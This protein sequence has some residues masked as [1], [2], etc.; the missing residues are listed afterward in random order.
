MSTDTI[1]LPQTRVLP[2]P[3]VKVK[4]HPSKW[5]FNKIFQVV[6]GLIMVHI[7][8]LVVV[9]LYY[10]LTQTWQPAND[11]WHS[12]VPN[13]DLR[14]DIR[15]VSEGLLGGLFAL[16]I[17]WNHY[18]KVKRKN[19]IDRVEIA[20]H[21]PNVKDGREISLGRTLM[22]VPL[23]LIYGSVGFF[24]MRYGIQALTE[25][26]HHTPHVQSAATNFVNSTQAHV[27]THSPSL[28][29]QMQ[30]LW[31]GNWKVKLTGL[32]A[33]LFFGK[34]PA[35]GFFDDLQLWFVE[36]RI[37]QGKRA[38]FFANQPADG[39]LARLFKWFSMTHLGRW[40]LNRR[41]VQGKLAVFIVG[42]LARMRHWV[43]KRRK[44]MAKRPA[45]Y[46]TP[47]IKARF[48][49]LAAS[50]TVTVDAGASR[51][52]W[53]SAL[54]VTSV[55]VCLGLAVWGWYIMNHFAK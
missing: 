17:N 19:L 24:A 9:A 50:G 54:I 1:A 53:Q 48:N 18:G 47:T 37:I 46:Y 42:L 51:S 11:A 4:H 20:L 26:L 45:F 7:G 35:K 40:F 3:L 6:A 25:W 30:D 14:H 43:L 13:G 28:G 15:D 16:G 21:I 10:L 31:T 49:D 55:P 44:V 41:I 38:M 39:R 12:L 29:A 23:V 2:A 34:R 8:T 33:A 22:L 32:A 52:V 36:R 27:S 5:I